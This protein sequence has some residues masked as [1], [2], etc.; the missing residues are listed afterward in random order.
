[1]RGVDKDTERNKRMRQEMEREMWDRD[2][3][4]RVKETDT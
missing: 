3:E 4:K 2:R 1:M